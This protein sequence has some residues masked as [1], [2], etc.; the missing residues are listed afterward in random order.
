VN[1][2]NGGVTTSDRRAEVF[3]RLHRGMGGQR[4]LLGKFGD[5]SWNSGCCDSQPFVDLQSLEHTQT[6]EEGKFN[7]RRMTPM[8]GRI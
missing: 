7:K 5:F 1:Q 8:S 4:D 3:P 6:T 2:Q